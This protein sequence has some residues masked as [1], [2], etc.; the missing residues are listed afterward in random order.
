MRCRTPGVMVAAVLMLLVGAAAAP[1]VERAVPAALPCDNI[2][3]L[4]TSD[5]HARA[6]AAV[7]RVGGG[8]GNATVEIA[9]WAD[10]SL[11]PDER[12]AYNKQFFSQGFLHAAGACFNGF[13]HVRGIYTEMYVNGQKVAE[14][15][16]AQ[17]PGCV[18]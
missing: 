15:G 5:G 7:Q 17:L 11:R 12:I 16:R 1:A 2:A 3:H 13:A 4:P 14:S 18:A 10:L 6:K 9:V 8:C